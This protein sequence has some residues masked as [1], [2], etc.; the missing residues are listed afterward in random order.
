M[1][2]GGSGARNSCKWESVQ[3]ID[4]RLAE[5]AVAASGG[6]VRGGIRGTRRPGKSAGSRARSGASLRPAPAFQDVEN[7]AGEPV[8]GRRCRAGAP[9]RPLGGTPRQA[10]GGQGGDPAETAAAFNEEH[11]EPNPC[12]GRR[13]FAEAVPPVELSE[14]EAVRLQA[15]N[16]TTLRS[17]R[18]NSTRRT[19]RRRRLSA[20]SF[21]RGCAVPSRFGK[22]RTTLR[23][24]CVN[25]GADERNT[26]QE[27][28]ALFAT[29]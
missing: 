19:D 21:S 24:T 23:W 8:G 11:A 12:R 28:H 14:R 7:G 4:G 13:S 16:P 29:S 1:R 18:L 26:Q 22:N 2:C 5:G 17:T 25:S 15:S 10:V 6:T 3:T 27:P 20:Q 9:A